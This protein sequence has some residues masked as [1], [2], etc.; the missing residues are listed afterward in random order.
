MDSQATYRNCVQTEGSLSERR[1][2]FCA[3]LIKVVCLFAF[4]LAL[5]I[6]LA[7]GASFAAIILA[8]LPAVVTFAVVMAVLIAAVLILRYCLCRRSCRCC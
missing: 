5:A 7:I 1:G 8:A 3:C 2:V 6:G 4:L